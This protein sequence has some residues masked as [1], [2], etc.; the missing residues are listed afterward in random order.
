VT[1]DAA[2]SG[3]IVGLDV[4]G[5]KTH[6]AAFDREFTQVAELRVSTGTGD[7]DTVACS[8][9]DT[10]AELE[11]NLDGIPIERIG[12]GIPGLVD[13]AD[14]S[15]RQAVNLGI[16]DDPLPIVDRLTAAYRVPCHVD[17]DVNAAALGAFHV[18]RNDHDSSDLAYLSIGTGIAAGVVINGRLHRGHRGVAGEIGHF[19]VVVDG[20]RCEC[21]LRGCLE[22]VASGPAIGRQWPADNGAAAE[23][24]FAA[25]SAGDPRAI[26]A[27]EPIADH[28]AR[29]V[30]LLALTFDV[31]QVVIGGGVAD[32]GVPMVDAI[33]EGIGRLAAES[34]FGRAL[35]RA[36][37]FRLTPA[38][39]IGAVG[40]AALTFL[41]GAS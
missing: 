4:G 24:L 8:V 40:A 29:A 30:Y 19:P 23:S 35:A 32:V 39:P 27:L 6:A 38:A 5:T 31:D 25:S 33:R 22:T 7:V 18:L 28:L 11:A 2:P 9:V 21:G 14:G 12:I 15:V 37:R 20:P 3:V 13:Q 1:A 41:D 34:C 17:N 36:D 16:G 26:A 10:M